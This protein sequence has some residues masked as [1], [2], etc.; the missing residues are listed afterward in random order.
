VLT[1]W[2]SSY[3]PIYAVVGNGIAGYDGNGGPATRAELNAP[4]A[5]ALDRTGD[6]LIADTGNN[7]I[8]VVAARTGHRYGQAMTA[9]HIYTIAGNGTAGYSGDGGPATAARFSIP[10]GVTQDG[11]G[12]QPGQNWRRSLT[13]PGSAAT[14]RRC[15]YLQRLVSGRL[16]LIKYA[17]R[18]SFK[19]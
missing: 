19:L 6:L 10:G 17:L 15:C 16:M 14:S 2:D 1:V 18:L 7:R 9:G 3:G 12:N 5:V 11:A 8:R 4:G 13:R